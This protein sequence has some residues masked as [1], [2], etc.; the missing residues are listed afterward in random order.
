[1]N[2]SS[3][4]EQDFLL[5]VSKALGRDKPLTEAPQRTEVGPPAFWK[6]EEAIKDD[7]LDLFVNNFES[8]GGHVFLAKDTDEATA[9]LTQWLTELHARNIICW[10]NNELKALIKSQDPETKFHYWNPKEKSPADLISLSEQADVG[11]TW[12][13][14]AIAY[15]GTMAVFSSPS[16]GRSVSLLP[17]THIGI[18][19]RSQLVRTMSSV[20]NHMIELNGQNNL[21]SAIS[22]ITGPSRTSDIEMDLSIGVHGPYRTWVI[23]IDDSPTPK[24]N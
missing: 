21:P 24:D 20:I 3:V 2:N 4:A 5:T 11:I 1:M 15:T 8:I 13:D 9:K 14:F 19:R 18:F 22:F 23:I 16:T 6:E 10:D 7:L 17:P 12:V